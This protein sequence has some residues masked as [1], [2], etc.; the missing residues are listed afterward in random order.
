MR[1]ILFLNEEDLFCLGAHDPLPYLSA[2][3]EAFLLHASGQYIQPL[4]LYLRWNDNKNR[5]NLMPAALTSSIYQ[6]IGVKIVTSVPENPLLRQLPRGQSLLML[7]SLIDGS[8]MALLAGNKISAMRTAAIST[9]AAKY[10]A[11]YKPKRVGLIG[12]GP[13]SAHHIHCL[14]AIFSELRQATVYDIDRERAE[15]FREQ[16]AASLAVDISIASCYEEAL[17][18]QDIVV[19]A[20]NTNEAFI[21][22]S[23]LSPGCFFA[24]VGIMEAKTSV[25]KHSQHVVVDDIEQCT[26]KDCPLTRALSE[27]LI[28]RQSIRELGS[29]INQSTIINRAQD[30]IVFFN[31]IGMGLVDTVCAA[32]FL[33]KAQEQ[34]L[35]Q[36]LQLNSDYY[37]EFG[38]PNEL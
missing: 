4:K 7:Y 26:Q 14:Q 21:E 27:D 25:I 11:K 15:R 18:D 1:E 9:V 16:I 13:I 35:G 29:I 24:N 28:K 17:R 2:V 20:T 10:L 31:A 12:A 33:N 3:E 22:G 32:Y 5:I 6:L 37:N 23:H 30:D 38:L 36:I 19:V 8:P 34:H